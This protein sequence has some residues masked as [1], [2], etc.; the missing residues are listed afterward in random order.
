MIRSKIA[1]KC[2][3]YGLIRVQKSA[4]LGEI[5]KNK[6]EMLALEIS[7]LVDNKD[8]V[9]IIPSCRECFKDRIIV[10]RLDDERIRKK[11]FVIFGEKD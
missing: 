3:N 8:A 2:K 6:V 7:E 9:F 4:F 11:D 5:T 1:S 10:G